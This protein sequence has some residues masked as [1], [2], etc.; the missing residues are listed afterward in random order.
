MTKATVKGSHS[1]SYRIIFFF[2]KLLLLDDS[3]YEYYEKESSTTVLF[4]FSISMT[5]F[6]LIFLYF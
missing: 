2:F 4:Y 6:T 3:Y 5:K 1:I